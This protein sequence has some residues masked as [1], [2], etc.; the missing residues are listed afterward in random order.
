MKPAKRVHEDLKR[1]TNREK[2]HADAQ[3]L[4]EIIGILQSEGYSKHWFRM[5]KT[6]A[7]VLDRDQRQAIR[8]AEL[9]KEIKQLK[10]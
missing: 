1:L 8:I 10:G 2:P 3:F 5:R 7:A 9:E 6:L 4:E